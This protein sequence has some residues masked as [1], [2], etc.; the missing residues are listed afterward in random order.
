[1]LHKS[2]NNCPPHEYNY[3]FLLFLNHEGSYDKDDLHPQG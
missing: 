2:L 1:L 3:Q